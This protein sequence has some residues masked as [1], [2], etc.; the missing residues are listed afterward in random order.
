M[1]WLLVGI[2]AI[3]GG[4][5]GM[6]Q[7]RARR[8]TAEVQ[9]DRRAELEVARRL[10]D[11]DVTVLGEQLQRLD[12]EVAALDEAV[13]IDYQTAL[14]TYESAQRAVPRITAAD[15]V[16]Q[17][18]DALT[19]GRFA[20]ACVQARIAGEPPP[21]RRT[22]CFFNPQHGPATADVSW[23]AGG[24]GTRI[25]PACAQDAARVANG[26]R[27]DVRR[28]KVNGQL[29]PY[30]EAGAAYLPYG[31]NYFTGAALLASPQHRH[32]DGGIGGIGG[33]IGG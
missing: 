13:R 23:T 21:Q 18:S 7:W 8:R 17:V 25:V 1:E 6:R 4:T 14:D 28:V 12:A 2:V 31:E 33:G 30:W 10:A 32:G 19:A 15:E 29:L 20:L 27:P 3:T 26:E 5:V 9:R 22:P 16:S 11:E 24:R